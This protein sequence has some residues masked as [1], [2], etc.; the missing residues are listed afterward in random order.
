MIKWY[1]FTP[2]RRKKILT[3]NNAIYEKNSQRFL[4]LAY[5]RIYR[6]GQCILCSTVETAYKVAI[7][8]R[9]NLLYMR[10]QQVNRWYIEVALRLLR[11][12]VIFSASK[13]HRYVAFCVYFRKIGLQARKP[14]FLGYAILNHWSVELSSAA[15]PLDWLPEVNSYLL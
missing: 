13:N 6:V 2:F 3:A 12:L 9:G 11:L 14:S 1:F 8:P 7:C 10:S 15:G 4:W 5:A